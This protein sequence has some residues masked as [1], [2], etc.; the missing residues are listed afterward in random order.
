VCER[1]SVCDIVEKLVNERQD[2]VQKVVSSVSASLSSSNGT[3]ICKSSSFVGKI[4]E[5][6]YL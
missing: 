4:S 6:S 1:E 3:M 2:L 5:K